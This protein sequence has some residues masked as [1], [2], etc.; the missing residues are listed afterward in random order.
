MRLL[1]P[2]FVL[3]CELVLA[4]PRREPST[5]PSSSGTSYWIGPG[6]SGTWHDPA[7]S[8]EGVV[9]QMLPDGSVLAV[10]FTY[11]AQGEAGEQAWLLGR[12]TAADRNTMHMDAV[13]QPMG[14]RF[15]AAFDPAQVQQ[16]SWGR[17]EFDFGDCNHAT[18]RYEGPTAF[19]SGERHLTRLTELDE[20][21]CSGERDLLP[22]GARA[23]SGL[24]A[25]SGT[26][27]VPTRSGEGWL[28]EEFAD[29]RSGVY[30]FTY[31]ESGRQRWI[32]G[33]GV[34]LTLQQPFTTRGARF[35]EAFRSDA[36]QMETFGDIALDFFSC[37]AMR[38][39]YAALRS[40]LGSAERVTTK[41]TGVAG[42]P[43]LD[44]TPQESGGLRWIER[45]TMPGSGN[46]EHAAVSVGEYIY[47]V[48]GFGARRGFL[49]F[50]PGSGQWLALPE[51]PDGR[52]HLSAFAHGNDVYAVG[53][54]QTGDASPYVGAYRYDPEQSGWEPR[55]EVP[56]TQ[57][58][59]SAVLY[60]R[61]FI[62]SEEGSLQEYE[63]VA[64]RTRS[65]GRADEPVQ[66]DHSQVVAFLDEIWMLGGR[67]PE[68]HIVS[69]YDPA[70]GRWRQGPGMGFQRAGFA[71]A[72]A[73]N[74]IVV[75]GGEML[76]TTPFQV[77]NA[78]EVYT[79]GTAD[80]TPGPNLPQGLHGVPGAG[81]NGRFFIFGGS[82]VGGSA[83]AG[84]SKVYE[85]ELP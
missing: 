55:P 22:N 64:R 2:W 72:T 9:L 42:A 20:L 56:R 39:D 81:W 24:R 57:A 69:I 6:I 80:W 61:A 83:A 8:G 26:W 10:W 52:H 85:L 62:G 66:R 19:G 50:S 28:V 4:A 53:G 76:S 74:R 14:A 70:S 71:A 38:L 37:D 68:T 46:S 63:P 51:L 13:V 18:L 43:C 77:I 82:T 31:D 40:E 48:G 12:A 5:T 36:V 73:G 11:P 17:F 1:L 59:N 27:F 44:G 16:H 65:V 7:R 67:S 15:G 21:Q 84:T 75:T 60:G 35:G 79:A 30:W 23:L 47:T 58:S 33:V 34:R 3:F 54:F 49:R 32:A 45:S 29:G 78:T 25:K 41:L